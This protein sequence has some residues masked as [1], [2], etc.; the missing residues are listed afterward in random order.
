MAIQALKGTKDVVPS[1][2]YLWQYVEETIRKITREY[3]YREIRTPVIEPTELFLRGV[4]DTTD[5][6]QKEMYTFDDKGGRSITLKPEGTGGVTRAFVEHAMQNDPLPA[7]M[8]YL[9]CPVFRYERPQAGRLREHHQ[10][11]VEV[12]GSA[13]AYTDAE[14]ISL[15]LTTLKTLG[16]DDLKVNINSIGCPQCRPNYHKALKEYYAQHLQHMCSQCQDRYERNPLRLLDCKEERCKT[17]AENAPQ[18]LDYLCDD[19]KSH[20]ETLKHALNCLGISYQINPT[21]VRGLDYYTKTVFEIISN[22]IGAQGTVCGGGRYD[23]LLETIGG[24][25]L[26][27]VGFGMGMERLLIVMESYGVLPAPP[28]R[29][30]AFCISMGSV[31]DSLVMANMLR[32]NGICADFDPLGRSMKAQMRYSEK[33]KALYVVI[34]GEDEKEKNTVLIRNMSTREQIEIPQEEILEYLKSNM[35]VTKEN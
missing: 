5:I 24:P 30:E 6:V 31:N 18:M 20:F 11:G 28:Q 4:G 3:G 10:F 23:H 26:P 9:N 33:L 1:E 12:F 25:S 29:C 35:H 2:A 13:S 21:I 32:Q 22:R 8:Y 14:V 15:A 7:K 16:V 19:C 17:Y 34:L 27:G